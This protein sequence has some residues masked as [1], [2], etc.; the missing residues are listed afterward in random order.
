[1]IDFKPLE[2]HDRKW[3]L[4]LLAKAQ[5]RGCEYTF[6]NNF[7]WGDIYQ[8]RVAELGGFLVSK[9][10]IHSTGYAY[11]AGQGNIA[12]VIETLIQDAQE[13]GHGF[14][15]F[16]VIEQ[17]MRLLEELFPGRFTFEFDRD[18]SDYIYESQK[19]ASLSGKKLHAKRNHLNRF[20]QNNP[21][22][23]YEQITEENI[24]ECH[25]MSEKWYEVQDYEAKNGLQVEHDAVNRAFKHFFEL[26]FSG[27]LIRA[28]GEIIAYS[29]G[30]P[31]TRDTFVVHIEKAFSEIQGAYQIINRQ[32]V[33]NN[34]MDYTYVNREE[35]VGNEGLRAAKLS[36]YPAMLHEKYIARLKG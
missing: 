34:C 30:E 13:A 23:K 12:P 11:P 17:N 26:E 33:R 28:G 32:F 22:W 36:Y 24:A 18:F 16:G 6:G 8:L 29:M 35:D 27:G 1:M 31:G 15:I 5:F 14:Y 19:L 2:L 10:G 3:M 21:D 7:M 25:A 20:I 4:P 9:S